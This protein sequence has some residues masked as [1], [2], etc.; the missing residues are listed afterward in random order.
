TAWVSAWLMPLGLVLLLIGGS[1]P[2][3]AGLFAIAFGISMGLSSIVRGTVPLQLFGPVGFGATMG[4]LAAPGLVIKAAA[5][6][7]FA[8]ALERGGVMVS[9][10]LLIAFS[11]LAAGALMLLARRT[12]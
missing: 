3:V 1:F 5:P 10:V 9:T 8:V 6:L 2:V 12:V 7:V 11:A 4:K